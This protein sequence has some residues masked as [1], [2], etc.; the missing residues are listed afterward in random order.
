VRTE[1]FWQRRVSVCPSLSHFEP[2]DYTPSSH[3][4][5]PRSII[6]PAVDTMP[7]LHQLQVS[8]SR[9]IRRRNYQTQFDGLYS[10]FRGVSIHLHN[11]KPSAKM[12][13]SCF[14]L[15]V[16]RR[17]DHFTRLGQAS[18][19]QTSVL[20][21][22]DATWRVQGTSVVAMAG[23]CIKGGEAATE[24]EHQLSGSHPTTTVITTSLFHST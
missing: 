22:S 14:M 6:G 18:A 15:A 2:G 20:A 7:D 5:S 13:F 8:K 11:A 10:C 3:Q 1:C 12:L 24:E 9:W 23:K 17:F 21:T 4:L 19:P 16:K